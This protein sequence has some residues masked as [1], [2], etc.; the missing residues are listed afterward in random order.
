MIQS[1]NPYKLT[2]MKFKIIV[3]GIF[4]SLLLSS[5]E[6]ISQA[7]T[8]YSNMNGIRSSSPNTAPIISIVKKVDSLW[9]REDYYAYSKKLAKISYY[10]D[11]VFKYDKDTGFKYNHGEYK[12]Y[13]ANELLE[14]SGYYREDKR[15]GF[16]ESYFPNG[17][18]RDSSQYT[19]GILT[20]MCKSWYSDGSLEKILQMD[21][22]GDGS[23]VAIGFFPN[24]NVSY[25]G[26]LAKGMRKIGP[27]SY[28]HENGNK[29]SMLYYHSLDQSVFALT[30]ELKYDTMEKT[31]YD[32]LTN[33]YKAICYDENGDETSACEIKNTTPEFI[34]GEKGWA[35]YLANYLANSL[36]GF[37]NLISNHTS[38]IVY[39]ADFMVDTEGKLIHILLSNKI[40]KSLDNLVMRIFTNPSGWTSAKHNNRKIPFMHRQAI[41][42]SPPTD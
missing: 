25:K 29:A 31:S 14:S 35:N 19:N 22:T 42:L 15:H 36:D 7:S 3:L 12:S 23:G 37:G 20:G 11:T 9:L 27:W 13:H 1:I 8:F 28:Y 17:M 24:G 2:K 34:R 21:S 18:M 4:A 10:K 41:N 5:I 39:I 6:A 30:P 16:F 38:T 33:Y 32:S 40:D 26:R